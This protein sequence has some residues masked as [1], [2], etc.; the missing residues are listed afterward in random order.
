[1]LPVSASYPNHHLCLATLYMFGGWDGTNDLCDLWQFSVELLQWK[2]LSADT[3]LEVCRAL[4]VVYRPPTGAH[5]HWDRECG[6]GISWDIG[7]WHNNNHMTSPHLLE[8]NPLSIV[9]KTK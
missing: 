7:G 4:H 9:D 6:L 2:C 1:M 8:C 3:S 5:G